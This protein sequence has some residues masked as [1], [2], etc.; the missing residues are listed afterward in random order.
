M[1]YLT[2]R[3]W[4]GWVLVAATD[5]GISAILLGDDPRALEQDVQRR[6]PDT[7]LA[8]DP[9]LKPTVAE[10]VRVVETPG[11]RLS[12]PLDPRGTEFERRVWQALREIP[13]GATAA[14]SDIAA[15]LGAPHASVEVAQACAS[16]PLAVVIPCHR[17]VR[18]SGA[19]G[20]Y[21]WGVRRK[22]ALL[23]REAAARGAS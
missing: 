16:N 6:F 5:D 17:V 3:C 22:R 23:A 15:R 20:G 12:R 9:E 2:G 18:K 4:L 7:S 11:Q 21:R 19:L 8:R 10:V 14:Y 13:A 1:R